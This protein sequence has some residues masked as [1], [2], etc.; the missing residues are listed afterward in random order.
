LRAAHGLESGQVER[1]EVATFHE[2]ARLAVRRPRTT[3]EAGYSTSF[4]AA[5]AMVRGRVDPEDVAAAALGDP[6][7]LRLSEGMMVTE[8]DDYNAAFPARR[9]AHVTLVLKDGR[10]LASPRTEASGDPEDPAAMEEVRAKYRAW[11]APALGEERA[12]AIE[13]AVE[14]LDQGSVGPLLDRVL[15]PTEGVGR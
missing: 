8:I 13:A 2:S 14:G 3:E 7:V 10:R 4:P 11:S 9:F 6:E 5:V 12:A 1:I 15:A